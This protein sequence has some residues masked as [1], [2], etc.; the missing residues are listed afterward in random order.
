MAIKLDMKK[1]YARINWDYPFT[2]LSKF[3]FP[4]LWFAKWQTSWYD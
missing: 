3:G 1:A 4:P 2:C